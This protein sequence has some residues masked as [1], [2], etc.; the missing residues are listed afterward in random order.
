MKQ[1][2]KTTKLLLLGLLILISCRNEESVLI[3]GPNESSFTA[4]S[5]L[6]GLMKRTTLKDGSFDNIIDKANCLSIQFPITVFANG[7]QVI[8]NSADDFETVENI[9]DDHDDDADT[10]QIQFPITVTQE[11]FKEVTL[12]DQSQFDALASTCQ[13]ENEID[14][15][16]ECVD[17]VFP[18]TVSTYNTVTEQFDK[19]ELQNDRELFDFIEDFKSD[20]ISNIEFPVVVIRS[21]DTE[22]TTNSMQELETEIT[23]SIDICDEDD[24]YDYNDD[25]CIACELQE[26]KDLLTGC[27]DWK[28]NRLTLNSLNLDLLYPLYQF[29]FA[30]NGTVTVTLLAIPLPLFTGTWTAVGTGQDIELNIAIPGLVEI[31]N[32]WTLTEIDLVTGQN[33]IDFKD[34]DDRLRFESA[35]N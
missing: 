1:T 6:A 27:D 30:T 31:S 21:D 4:D 25:D 5:N 8:V 20:D 3:P 10:M 34:D 18:I 26:F 22:I 23:S 35:C 9:F 12:N 16:I 15:D 29:N 14:Q 7:I 33:R 32:I 2:I 17:F 24:D 11:D 19:D 28:I 13:G